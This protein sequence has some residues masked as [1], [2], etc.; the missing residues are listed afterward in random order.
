MDLRSHLSPETHLH[1][2]DNPIV[3]DWVSA[4]S[5]MAGWV[6]AYDPVDRV[7]VD[8]MWLIQVDHGQVSHRKVFSVL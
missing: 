3:G 8:R 4:D 7:P 5:E 2:S 1:Y 6:T